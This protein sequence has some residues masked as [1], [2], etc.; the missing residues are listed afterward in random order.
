MARQQAFQ[1]HPASGPISLSAKQINGQKEI[2]IE[3]W[4]H[5]DFPQLGKERTGFNKTLADVPKGEKQSSKMSDS[6]SRPHSDL[7]SKGYQTV[8]QRTESAPKGVMAQ[9]RILQRTDSIERRTKQTEN[10]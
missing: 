9:G 2:L 10:L 5:T 3:P 6:G 1:K 8:F 4:N 7:D